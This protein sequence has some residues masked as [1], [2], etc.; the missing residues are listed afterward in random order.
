[1]NNAIKTI[2][3]ELLE[4]IQE[5]ATGITESKNISSKDLGSTYFILLNNNV[6]KP[7]CEL[8]FNK[9]KTSIIIFRGEGSIEHE[10]EDISD[11]SKYKEDILYNINFLLNEDMR[12]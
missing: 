7:I 12:K 5:M 2:K 6:R 4:V 9:D 11:L 1:M 10:I 8:L 3:T